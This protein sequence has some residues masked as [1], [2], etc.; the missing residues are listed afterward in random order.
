MSHQY[1]TAASHRGGL[2]RRPSSSESGTTAGHPFVD[3][4]ESAPSPAALIATTARAPPARRD[5][6]LDKAAGVAAAAAAAAAKIGQMPCALGDAAQ[7][8]LQTRPSS[9]S[10]SSSLSSLALPL[11]TRRLEPSFSSAAPAPTLP[12]A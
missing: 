9:S 11:S 6:K 7:Q 12:E 8:L 3:G 10:P 4:D 2:R 5:S 1:A